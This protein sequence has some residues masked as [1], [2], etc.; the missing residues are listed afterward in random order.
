MASQRDLDKSA[1]Q[2]R[3]VDAA[4]HLFETAGY[5]T[6]TMAQIARDAQTSRANLYLHF[7][8]KSQIVLHRMRSLEPE[9]V[10][11]YSGLD[12]LT[13]TLDDV[14][15]WLRQ[16][17]QLWMSHLPEFDAISRA[18][19][20]DAEVFQ[21]WLDLHRRIS[22]DKAHTLAA[23]STM[24]REAWAVHLVTLMISLEQNFY[25][26]YVRGQRDR[27][28]LVLRSLAAQWVTLLT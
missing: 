7:T 14:I 27:E 23:G 22:E 24:P 17:G 19:T 5:E 26:L 13:G 1:T 12:E 16:A 28:D 25:F 20:A 4:M 21:E 3:I 15:V 8:S 2:Q 9:V 10:G 11:L 18:M 6:T